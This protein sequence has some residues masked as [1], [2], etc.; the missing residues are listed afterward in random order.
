MSLTT[1]LA[2]SVLSYF[3]R[4]AAH[5]FRKAFQHALRSVRRR[6][7]RVRWSRL[8][9]FCVFLSGHMNKKSCC[10]QLSELNALLAFHKR[11]SE[12]WEQHEIATLFRCPLRNTK[13]RS[14][15]QPYPDTPAPY[16]PQEG[17]PKPTHA[18][19][20]LPQKKGIPTTMTTHE[21][22]TSKPKLPVYFDIYQSDNQLV[23]SHWHAH[24]EI[25]YISSG[26]MHVICR[27]ESFLLHTG[28][29]F[30]VNSGD[31]HYTRT[32]GR[33]ETYLL[34][35]PF[36]FFNQMLPGFASI[37][38]QEYFSAEKYKNDPVF[39]E[40]RDHLL[41]MGYL[42][43]NEK[44]GY[45]FL[46]GS[47]LHHFLYILYTSYVLPQS[48]STVSQDTKTLTRLKDIITYVERHYMEPLSLSDISDR[49]ALN[50][51]YFCRFFK[52]NMG[53][54]FLEYVNMVRLS[55]IYSDL[56]QTGDSITQIMERHGFINYKVFNRMFKEVY[57]CLP[58]KVRHQ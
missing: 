51:E 43:K 12:F 6:G 20:T 24:V 56:M 19:N 50:P 14:P 39:C 15:A 29:I 38:F 2:E 8:T 31:I 48:Q 52:K 42:Y 45:Q 58:S 47:H 30:L 36:D 16:R 25:L 44:N 49:F 40:M 13:K 3:T 5:I 23:P 46:F 9:A 18:I 10:G 17:S 27:E 35:I 34:Q 32:I 1:K 54:T 37:R 57:G 28:D 26:S 4:T 41:T 22:I 21:I 33:T 7:V 53:F 11:K 55:H